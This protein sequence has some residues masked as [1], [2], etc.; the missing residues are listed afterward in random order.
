[1]AAELLLLAHR[2]TLHTGLKV[3]HGDESGI[4]CLS[5][6]YGNKQ[7]EQELVRHH[8]VDEEAVHGEL[9]RNVAKI[10]IN[11]INLALGIKQGSKEVN[12]RLTGIKFGLK[13]ARSVLMCDNLKYLEKVLRVEIVVC[14]YLP[15]EFCRF[16]RLCG[17]VVRVS[18]YRYR[19]PGFDSRRYQIF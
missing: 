6:N 12:I 7:N 2:I 13:M 14:R 18:G 3:R 1:M 5:A 17:L 9:D 19:G 11:D 16:D 10:E 8:Q 4:I 15:R